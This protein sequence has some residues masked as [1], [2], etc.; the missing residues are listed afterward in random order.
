MSDTAL[1]VAVFLACVVEAVEALTIVLAA[2]TA[3]DW[4]SAM[5]GVLAGLTTLA[6]TIAALGPALSSIPMSGLRLF[7]G[8]VLL[9]FG[10]QWLR[11][12][13]LRASGHK[14]LHDEAQIYLTELANAE[15]AVTVRRGVVADW[16]A[17]TLSFKGVV[18]EGLEVAFI[19]LTF[20]SNQHNLPL[21]VLAALSAVVVVTALGLALKAP[22]ASVPE[23]SM[24]F[25]VGVMLTSF[26]IFW[27]AEGAGVTWPG[28]D[29]A[30]L[31]L[32]PATGA[33]AL[34]LVSLFRRQVDEP[35]PADDPARLAESAR[36]T[37]SARATEGVSAS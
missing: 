20:G 33:Y 25:V 37:D 14:A 18:L 21:A 15:R 7:V 6:V 35:A 19:A 32:I 22:L 34:V 27:G 31:V 10:L 13:I 4:R 29:A 36:L 30:L 1:F 11:K 23:N 12:A 2:G 8:G 24:K 28:S 5:T 3:R 9:V 26:G 16:Y 17:F